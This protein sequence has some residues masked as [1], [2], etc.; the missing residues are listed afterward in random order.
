MCSCVRDKPVTSTDPTGMIALSGYNVAGNE[1]DIVESV[2]TFWTRGSLG[3]TPAD[4][5]TDDGQSKSQ[6][7]KT[8][9]E[10]ASAQNESQTKQ[11]SADDVSNGVKAYDSDKGDKGAARV[12][13][14]L[15]T[16]GKDFTATGDVVR[17][18]VKESGVKLPKDAD[19]VLGNVDSI[20]RTGDKVV[21]TN[22]GSITIKAL[23][24]LGKTISFTVTTVDGK[25]ALRSITGIS[26]G[27][28]IL[29]KKITSYGP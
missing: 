27:V 29:Q 23:A 10:Q 5:G 25:P 15:D 7:N 24:H 11:L 2:N 28:S 3:P 21:I 16:M 18:G 26:A 6:G 20:T 13:K 9:E 19:K 4:D 8:P 1:E 22:E 17:A 12:V 14:A